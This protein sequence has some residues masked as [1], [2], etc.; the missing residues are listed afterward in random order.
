MR[1]GVPV[2][3]STPVRVLHLYALIYTNDGGLIPSRVQEVRLVVSAP[4]DTW[5]W[6]V[7][8]APELPIVFPAEPTRAKDSRG[9]HFQ[10][11]SFRGEGLD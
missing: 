1:A 5:G 3:D 2:S 6:R 4:P 10:S 7:A 9:E 8:P 11:T